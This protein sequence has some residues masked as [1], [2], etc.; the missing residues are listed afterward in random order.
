MKIAVL[1]LKIMSVFVLL[2]ALIA[3]YVYVYLHEY[4]SPPS[5]ITIEKGSNQKALESLREASVDVG[6]IDVIV[7]RFL[8][9][10]KSGS[11]STEGVESRLDLLRAMV[12]GK[13]KSLTVTLIPSETTE[14]FFQNLAKKEG[15]DVD[16]LKAA[17]A[18]KTDAPEGRL[19]PETYSLPYD[20]NEEV[21]V[22][23]LL[24]YSK[25]GYE[26]LQKKYSATDAQFAEKLVIASI[27]EKE[28]V[29]SE[30]MRV[31]ASVIYNRL[32][33]N[34]P[35]QMDGSLNY[36]IYSHQK[37]TPERIREDDTHY[38]TY[39][40]KALPKYPVCAPSKEAINAAFNPAKTDFLY[41]VK[42][43]DGKHNFSN[44]YTE[45]KS[46]IDD[47]KKSNR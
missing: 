29:N 40:N 14:V 42:G 22:E 30:E 46:N 43:A 13:E 20:A 37:V 44:S 16:K 28:S 34:M 32:K 17:Y 12:L 6:F 4:V 31:V 47:V 33:I 19:Y 26:T 21:V 39:K 8:G 3:G 18:S 5:V 15:F 11:I 7:L 23:K 10:A 1:F 24:E 36:G 38:N 2:V 35:L 45:H 41:F 9:G 27:V 25:K